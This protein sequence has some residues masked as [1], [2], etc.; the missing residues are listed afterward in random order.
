M[1]LVHCPQKQYIIYNVDTDPCQKARTFI[2]KGKSNNH[3]QTTVWLI[4]PKVDYYNYG[5]SIY[6]MKM[7]TIIGRI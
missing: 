4:Y 2:T 5:R 1:V 7:Q 6:C 3:T